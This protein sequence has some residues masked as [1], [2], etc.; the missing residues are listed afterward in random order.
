MNARIAVSIALSAVVLLASVVG[1]ASARAADEVGLSSDGVVWYDA[2]HRPLFDP[3]Q[4]WVPGDVETASFYV[5]NQG[6]SA[7]Q[8][9]IEVR[10]ADGARLLADDDIEITARA[11]GREWLAV[12]NGRASPWLTERAIEQGGQVRVDVTVRFVWQAPNSTML[13]RLPL[14]FRV[15]LVETGPS[16][17]PGPDSGPDGL[18]PD[19]GSAV[20]LIVVWVGAILVGSGLALLAGARR[21]R[22]REQDDQ[23]GPDGQD[24]DAAIAD[25]GVR[26]DG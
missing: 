5:R 13:D 11:E 19:T 21:R 2:L 6:P 8:L 3:A 25:E 26:V 20:S 17:G 24:E 9:T 18:L 22:A 10:S 14:D 7:A 12:E 4:R 15:R 1:A 16:D 23:D